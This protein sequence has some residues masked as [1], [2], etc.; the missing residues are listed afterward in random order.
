MFCSIAQFEFTPTE[1][2]AKAAAYSLRKS[3]LFDD[4]FFTFGADKDKANYILCGTVTSSRY[5][6]KIISY[7][8]SVVCPYLWI[9]GLPCGT[10]K[11]EIALQLSLVDGTSKKVLWQ[12]S[13]E[14]T[15]SITQGLYYEFGHDVLAYS[16]L[17]QEIMNDAVRG[18]NQALIA[19][20]K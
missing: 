6:G 7:G 3:C 10:S 15:D 13:Y 11:D 18:I 12:K 2:L 9:L 20:K 19:A 5:T 1:D 4:A 14:M 16:Q 8:V 17:M